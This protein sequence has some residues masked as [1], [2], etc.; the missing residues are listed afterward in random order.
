M[1]YIY[2]VALLI[3]LGIESNSIPESASLHPIGPC[4]AGFRFPSAAGFPNPPRAAVFPF[5]SSPRLPGSPI[6]IKK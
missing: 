2:I 3:T 5:P 6:K 1:K 4:A